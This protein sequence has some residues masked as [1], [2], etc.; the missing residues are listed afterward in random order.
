M[1]DIKK[2]L[3]L[4]S[5]PII[6]GQAAEFDYAGTQACRSLREEGIKVVLVNSNPATIMTDEDIADQIYIEP[7]TIEV[8]EEI[9][10]IEKPDGILGT[11]GGQTGLNLLCDLYNNGILEKYN[12]KTL[13]TSVKS[14]EMAEDR[15]LFRN[16]LENLDQ[17]VLPSFAV[18]NVE[19]AI[20]SANKIG[21]PVVIRPAYTLGGTG[22]GIAKNETELVEIA[23]GGLSASRVGQVLIEKSLVG[24]KEIEYEVMRDGDGNVITICNMEN[25][26][27]MGVHTGDSI[28]V[29]PSQ[30]LNDK[31]YQRL[32]TASLDIITGLD[33]KGGCNVQLA[34]RPT[35]L[36]SEN[37]G[38]GSG[39]EDEGS[40]Y[41]VI[42]VN[43]R[44]SRSS[45][46]ASKATGYPIARVA[47]KIAIGKSLH[48]ISNAVTKKTTAAFEPALDYCVVKIPRW[49][50]DKFPLGDRSLG[51]QMK[52]TGE[53]MAID[54]NFES[55]LQKAVRSLE[56]GRSTLSWEDPDW[57]ADDLKILSPDDDRIWKLATAIRRGLDFQEVSK[58][59]GI[60]PWF[61]FS[62]NKIV[63]FEKALEKNEMTPELLLQAKMLGF[64]D[65]QIANFSDYLSEDIRQLRKKWNI[66]PVY[67]MVD[68]CAGEFEAYTPYF[69]STYSKENEAQTLKSDKA[70]V[71]GSGPI[72][73]GQGIEFDYCSVHAAFALK[74]IGVK[75][76]MINSNPETVSTDFDTSDRLYFEPL[77]EESIRNIIENENYSNKMPSSLVQFGGQTAINLSQR[78]GKLDLPILGS[79]SESIDNA[80][81]R[82]KF[83]D[84]S[85]QNSIPLPPGGMAKDIDSAMI[86]AED[87]KFPVLLR[88]SYVL[89]GRAME[90]VQNKNELV[91]YFHKSQK[92]FPN[93]EILIDHY[94]SGIEV[95]VDAISDGNGVLIPG[96]M[97]HIERA[98]VHSGDSMAVYP[99]QSLSDEEIKMIVDYTNK[100]ATSL[101]IIGLMNIQFIVAGDNSRRSIYSKINYSEEPEIYVIEVNPRSSRTIPFISKV[102]R[103]PM[104]KI[105]TKVMNGK[106][107]K[108]LGFNYGLHPNKNLV[109]VKAPVFSMS[110][111]SGVDSFL[112][113]E[114]KSTGEVMGIDCSF[115][116]A[117]K[118]ALISSG[119]NVNPGSP[120][121]LSIANPDKSDSENLVKIL[122]KNGHKLFATEG[123][124]KMI[125]K[126][127]IK[128]KTV[129]KRLSNN[130]GENVV[131]I[132]Q[133][134]TVSAVINTVTGDRQALQ[135]G[136]HIRRAA[137]LMNI[138]C[139]TSIDT[140]LCA[141]QSENISSDFSKSKYNVK[142]IADYLET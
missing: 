141:I 33:I 106:S 105:A 26:D 53:V 107:I 101:K 43:P 69:Y 54:R 41:Y 65:D 103:I 35:T 45:A 110:K 119:L 48:Q 96:I 102:T 31:D 109:A 32:R 3:V 7:L 132:I 76:V 125:S 24:W 22:G 60:D 94:L 74:E 14:V 8:V 23:K 108:E 118:K 58:I 100:I 139:F 61:T 123:T 47:A 73:I 6:I 127:G 120:I 30:T 93:Q 46:L 90:I 128:V 71:I 55:A 39:Y 117:M 25:L 21:F 98:G 86:V 12:V 37:L 42:E 80:S 70:I 77:D 97:Q 126:L 51:T 91:N 138:P 19:D 62:I 140:A 49:P 129:E 28:V 116:A 131:D 63:S 1:I 68:T 59:T 57:D 92:E 134:G 115:T 112:G 87:V 82:A 38:E 36:I 78:L 104:V 89:G 111:L 99:A 85:K 84:L 81:D 50:F 64:T 27:P 52:A 10:K 95:E 133:N 5:G 40:M 16:L 34:Y 11:L 72:R 66:L 9:I 88:P 79:S 17:P 13:G 44:V 56:N 124:A 67:K 29:A 18:D 114:M 75:S 142:S 15:E 136:F 122:Q 137:T 2:V 130:L 83:E 4:G 121:L 20:K 135:D 113:P